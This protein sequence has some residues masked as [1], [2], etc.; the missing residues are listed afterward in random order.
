M[1]PTTADI[2]GQA[3]ADLK[4][5]APVYT[6]YRDYYD[7]DHRL[8]FAT[9]KF[10]NAFGNLF[11]A[12][13][14]N[15]SSAVVDAAADRLTLTGFVRD[16]GD[17]GSVAEAMNLWRRNRMDRRAGEAHTEALLTGDSYLIVWPNA[18][19]KAVIQPQKAHNVTVGYDDENPGRIIWAVKIWRV[20]KQWRLNLYLPDRVEKWATPES[21]QSSEM[22]DRASAF[23]EYEIVGEAW[24]LPN[25]Y[26]VVPVFHMANNAGVGE[27]GRSEL[28]DVIP[29]QDALNKSIADMLVAQEFVA[30]P[31]RII[32]GWEPEIDPDT[33]QPRSLPSSV[34]RWTAFADAGVNVTQLAG[35]DLTQFHSTQDG[36]RREIAGV[37]RT[38]A[39]FLVPT[40]GDWPSGE[41]LKTAESQFIAK[42]QDR[43]VA[44]GNVWED[45]IRFALVIE[46]VTVEDLSAVWTDPTPR[47]ENDM[48][49]R[50]KTHVDAGA[51]YGGALRLVGFSDDQVKMATDFS[52]TPE[53]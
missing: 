29:L 28:R 44:F 43:Q 42:I 53:M 24:P 14:D 51:A 46:N 6:L 31:Q 9:R 20:R 34:E 17:S 41:A 21:S 3:L 45:A 52:D 4:R 11:A 12:F 18:E 1:D 25:P 30:L 32:T 36:F 26:G 13:A 27:F 38:P 5:R 50:V 47:S 15:L 8:T 19:G 23:Q 49:Q 7:G 48:V 39:H 2:I 22:P 10:S 33:G 37:S 35:A 40:T 16:S